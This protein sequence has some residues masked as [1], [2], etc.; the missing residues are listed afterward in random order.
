MVAPEED[1]ESANCYGRWDDE[2][3]MSVYVRNES[4]LKGCPRVVLKIGDRDVTA[5]LDSGAEISV[6]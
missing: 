5:I 3:D 4:N 1:G 6:M 2:L